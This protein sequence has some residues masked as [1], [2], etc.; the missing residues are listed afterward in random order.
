MHLDA[1]H[2]FFTN[3]SDCRLGKPFKHWTV[4]KEVSRHEAMILTARA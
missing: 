3:L 4:F 1:K 2:S